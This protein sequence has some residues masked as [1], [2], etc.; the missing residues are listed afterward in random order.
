[1]TSTRCCPRRAHV[2]DVSRQTRSRPSTS[3]TPIWRARNE[4]S[5]YAELC[6]PGVSTTTYGSAPRRARSPERLEEP[7][8]VVRDRPDAVRRRARGTRAS[9]PAGSRRR[10][11]CPTACGGCPRGRGSRPSP[12][13]TR[14][15][16]ATCTRTLPGGSIPC[17][18]AVEVLRRD[19]QPAGHDAVG[20]IS[21]G[22]YTSASLPLA[23]SRPSSLAMRTTCWTC[24]T[25]VIFS[26]CGPDGVLVAAARVQA[27]GGGH[28]VEGQH[29]AHQGLQRQAG[30][31]GDPADEV[32]HV[33]GVGA[34]EAATDRDPG[35]VE[36]THVLPRRTRRSTVS[37]CGCWPSWKCGW[38]PLARRRFRCSTTHSGPAGTNISR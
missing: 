30:A 35:H 32:H 27:H 22:P 19:D 16:P 5:K 17:D 7:G 36:R 13:R 10:T 24:W 37:S 31:V 33:V 34:V 6:T 26:P 1:M 38:I 12:S 20:M 18:G 29:A 8:R 21:P 3:S 2:D 11:R 25:E 14:S 28:R 9:S 15:M 4:C 23:T